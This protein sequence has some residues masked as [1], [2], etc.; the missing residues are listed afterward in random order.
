M[1]GLGAVLLVALALL[2]A[3]PATARAICGDGVLEDGEGCDDGGREAGDGC[4]ADCAVE[5]GFACD[6]GVRL[7]RITAEDYPGSSPPA[8]W[9]V[10]ADG[11][12]AVQTVNGNASVGL[13]GADAMARTW[14]FDVTVETT[15]G[16]D[17]FGFVLG[18]P[19]LR[20]R[21]DYLAI[22][23]L[24]FGEIIRLMLVNLTSITGGP[25]GIPSIPKMLDLS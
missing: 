3:A 22:V 15:D 19:V 18:F 13:F 10:A 12:S 16:D 11:L 23:T 1:K 5:L 9:D 21:G 6:E 2:A 20:L 14:V 8:S 4:D 17:W 7:G 24:G 25:D